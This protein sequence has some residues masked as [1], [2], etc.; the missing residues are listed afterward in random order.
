MIGE[1]FKRLMNFW[2]RSLFIEPFL[3]LALIIGFTI[4]V[5]N[6][7][8]EKER[9][10]FLIYFLSGI[11]LFII[12]TILVI[13]RLYPV[14]ESIEIGEIDNT[15][16]ELIEFIAF[17]HFFRKCLRT[18]R[19]KQV[20]K[21]FLILLCTI[22]SFFLI[23]LIFFPYLISNIGEYSLFTN[24]VEFFFLTV[25]CLAYFYE[26]YSSV[27]EMNLFKRPSFLIVT[28]CFFYTAL[29]IPF[30]MIASEMLHFISLVYYILTACHYL[31]FIILIFGITKA[32]LSKTP[33]TI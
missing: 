31:T 28:S 15:I 5:F 16:F 33:I 27:P 29:M 1:I 10:Y 22:I 12:G 26:L 23:G 8:K 30:F 13:S 7:H 17:Y 32:F 18:R 11:L 2:S 14:K 19:I 4:G 3:V 9:I 24:V 6:A 20:L 21:L 25:L